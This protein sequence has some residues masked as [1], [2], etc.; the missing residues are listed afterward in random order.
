M[1][2]VAMKTVKINGNVWYLNE[3]GDCYNEGNIFYNVY[4]KKSNVNIEK[5][6]N[7]I[8]KKLESYYKF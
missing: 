4:T 5:V 1:E 8:V 6:K 7:E 2:A 3:Q